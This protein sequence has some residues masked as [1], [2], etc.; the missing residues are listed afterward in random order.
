M[1]NF[2]KFLSRYKQFYNY[3]YKLFHKK[4]ILRIFPRNDRI[5]SKKKIEEER[6]RV[7]I[8]SILI[9]VPYNDS[10]LKFKKKKEKRESL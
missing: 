3:G 9:N 5:L 10:N 8:V 1:R 4:I 6:K 7:I 2:I